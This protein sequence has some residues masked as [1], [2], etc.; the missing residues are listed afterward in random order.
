[1]G[2]SSTQ[3]LPMSKVTPRQEVQAFSHRLRNALKQ[4][5]YKGTATELAH[6][7]N[8]RDWGNGITA[9]ATRNWLN[10][11]SIPKQTRLRVLCE[12]LQVTPADLLFGP[13][14]ASDT[15]KAQPDS[16]PLPDATLADRCLWGTYGQLSLE[17]RRMVREMASGL[18]NL[19]RQAPR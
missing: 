3:E 2:R 11:V 16:P 6:L 4:A 1:M 18:L 19:E 5:G 15:P 8:L 12:L 7:F 9:H 14:A 10:G 13:H 17:H